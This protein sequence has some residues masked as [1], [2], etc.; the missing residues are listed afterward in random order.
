M[1]SDW[2]CEYCDKKYKSLIGF[3]KHK[4]KKKDKT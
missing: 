4:C 3:K 1:N 2:V